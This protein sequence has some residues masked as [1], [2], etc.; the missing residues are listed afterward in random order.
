M[1]GTKICPFCAEEILLAAKKCKH[2]G[3]FLDAA[4]PQPRRVVKPRRRNSPFVDSLLFLGVIICPIIGLF[5]LPKL[6]SSNEAE[7]RDGAIYLAWT[8]IMFAVWLI[9]SPLV[10]ALLTG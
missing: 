6:A 10:F 1:N 5:A 9:L 7:R 8:L 3:E 4:K 2:C